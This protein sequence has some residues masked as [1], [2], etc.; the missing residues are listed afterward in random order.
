MW[1]IWT[2][3]VPWEEIESTP[4][5]FATRLSALV[6]GGARPKLPLGCEPAP[7]GYFEL[8]QQCWAD[9]PVERPRFDAVVHM[10]EVRLA[11]VASQ[12]TQ[13]HAGASSGSNISESEL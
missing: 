10:L 7:A 1:E 13:E 8:M 2:R 9:K 11:V 12:D 5:T 6:T 4:A 3:A